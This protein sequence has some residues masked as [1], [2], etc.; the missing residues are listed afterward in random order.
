MKKIVKRLK[1]RYKDNRKKHIL[2]NF[3][4]REIGKGKTQR[5]NFLDGISTYL[6]L[7]IGFAMFMTYQTGNFFLSLY[8]TLIILFFVGALSK[9]FLVRKKKAQIDKINEELKSKK[10]I[11]EFAYLKKEDFVSFLKPILEEYYSMKLEYGDSPIDLLGIKENETYGLKVIKTTMN[12]RITFRELDLFLR[13][14]RGLKIDEG[15]LI[16]NSYFTDEVR[17]ESKVILHDFDSL[18]EILKKTGNYPKQEEIESFIIDRYN[19][20]R[21]VLKKEMTTINKNK[22][23]K[24]YGVFI[25]FYTLSYFVNYSIYYKI[26]GIIAFIIATFLGGYRISEYIKE[27]RNYPLT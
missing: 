14:L 1:D 13:E 5:A 22:I 16:T 20:R 24:L 26:M 19:D 25:I 18:K 9:G 12:D 6:I 21:N 11:K 15:I 4:S 7:A 3:Y 2:N 10:L 23:Y 8:M 27:K 17:S